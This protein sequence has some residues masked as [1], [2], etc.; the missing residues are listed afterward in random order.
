MNKLFPLLACA[1]LLPSCAPTMNALGRAA[2]TS[3]TLPA[4]A[5]LAAGQTW[6]VEGGSV[7]IR[8][9]QTFAL[10]EVFEIAPGIYS[11]LDSAGLNVAQ[12]G[13]AT[14]N[15]PLFP[16]VSYARLGQRLDFYW[17]EDGTDYNC[18]I[19]NAAPDAT[20]F[21]GRLSLSGST[22]GS[23]TAQRR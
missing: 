4:S 5:P 9:R 18:R 1:A 20:R 22:F 3:A 10:T 17:T 7:A 6:D 12:R 19:E 11:N 23:C 16:A 15:A 8:T 21:T 14:Q 2:G 13:R